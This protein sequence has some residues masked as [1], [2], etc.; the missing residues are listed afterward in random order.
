MRLLITLSILFVAGL[1]ALGLAAAPVR[2]SSPA[3]S[4]ASILVTPTPGPSPTPQVVTVEQTIGMIY[5][6]QRQIRLLLL[7]FLPA[8]L[9]VLAFSWLRV[10][11]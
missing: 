5:E 8:S 3:S 9:L 11:Q 1:V 10:R 7:L 4:P 2:A 6:E